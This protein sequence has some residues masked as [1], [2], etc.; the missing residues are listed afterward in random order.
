MPW[1]EKGG[2]G[3]QFTVESKRK[4]W[5]EI[6]TNAITTV[7]PETSEGLE[8]QGSFTGARKMA[9]AASNIADAALAAFEKRWGK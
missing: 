6:F 8:A 9:E 4:A 5:W 1:E 7:L 3:V 2:D